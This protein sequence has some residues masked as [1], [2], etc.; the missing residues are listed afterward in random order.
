MVRAIGALADG[1]HLVAWISEGTTLYVQRYDA[2]GAKVGGET[3]V[4]FQVQGRGGAI[5]PSDGTVAVLPDASVVVAYSVARDVPQ[6]D[7]RVLTQSGVY[8]QRFD[9]TG[10]QVMGETEVASRSEVAHSRSPAYVAVQTEVLADGSFV[11]GWGVS[12]PSSVN[13]P[14]ITY[15]HRRFDAQGAAAGDALVAGTV[16]AV[17]GS[18]FSLEPDAQ[19]GYTL[20]VVQPDASGNPLVTITHYPAGGAAAK[21]IVTQ[22]SGDALLLPLSSGNYVL[23][24]RDAEG[25]FRQMLD[26]AGSPTSAPARMLSVPYAARELKDGTFVALAVSP[27]AGAGGINNTERFNAD[28][29][30]RGELFSI[31]GQ[32]VALRNNGFAVAYNVADRI[33]AA[34]G[35]RRRGRPP[36]RSTRLRSW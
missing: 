15:Y 30:S 35:G 34:A 14:T 13:V 36:A 28:G 22:R 33:E 16:R 17:E 31:N 3:A 18:S 19:G 4:P 1:G 20:A 7:G 5:V 24:G 8:F 9:A 29:S 12:Q 23:F 21:Q 27:Y 32:P 10:A 25:P 2:A 11:V 6:P 26:A